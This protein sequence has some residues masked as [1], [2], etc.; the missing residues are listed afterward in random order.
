LATLV[1]LIHQILRR[2]DCKKIVVFAQFQRLLLLMADVLQKSGISFVV[3]RGSIRSCEKAFRSF[4]YDANVRIIL[5]ASDKSI[6]GVHL[7]EANH[8]IAVHPMLCSRGVEDEYAALWQAIGR[9]RRLMQRQTCHVWQLVT[10]NTIEE[11]L[12]DAQTALARQK[13]A[14]DV[15]IVW[16]APSTEEAEQTLLAQTPTTGTKSISGPVGG[17]QPTASNKVVDTSTVVVLDNAKEKT[18]ARQQLAR[19]FNRAQDEEQEEEEAAAGDEEQEAEIARD[20]AQE[21]TLNDLPLMAVDGDTGETDADNKRE[22]NTDSQHN[23]HNDVHATTAAA[24]V[25]APP[26]EDFT[27]WLCARRYRE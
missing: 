12:Y 26:G 27:E 14:M 22:D 21:L 23:A 8:L 18:S 24:S 2:R 25:A 4:R 17:V 6:S 20:G 15:G 9:I 7:V 11:Q 5:L 16:N 19:L 10:Q 1:P 3:A 13:Q